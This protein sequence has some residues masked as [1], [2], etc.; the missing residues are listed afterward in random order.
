M[1]TLFIL[2]LFVMSGCAGPV[3]FSW[4]DPNPAGWVI[5]YRF[6]TNGVLAATGT[7]TNCTVN[8]SAGVS[9]CTVRFV[10]P[11][12]LES[13]ASEPSTNAIPARPVW[14]KRR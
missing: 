3:I 6:Y 11:S 12:G 9:V 5:G 8:L 2:F 1:R 4:S 13:A 14:L 7:G 10:G